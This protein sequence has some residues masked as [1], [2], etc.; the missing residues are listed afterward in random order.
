M[1]RRGGRIDLASLAGSVGD[2]SSV[3][4]KP[5]TPAKTTP[6]GVPSDA[7]TYIDGQLLR[8]CS[9]RGVGRQPT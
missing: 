7:S 5:V 1:A 3:D 9:L 6:A 8:E 4:S 2:N